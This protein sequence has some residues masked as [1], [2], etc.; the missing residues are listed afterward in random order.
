MVTSL[1]LF[2]AIYEEKNEILREKGE[3]EGTDN[4]DQRVEEFVKFGNEE[5]F[6][7]KRKRVLKK[8]FEETLNK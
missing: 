5:S 2:G 8:Y 4:G 6:S 7:R 3:E 1:D